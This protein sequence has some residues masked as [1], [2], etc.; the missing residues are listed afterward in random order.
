MLIIIII[1]KNIRE[2]LGPI[3]TTFLSR[4]S[5]AGPSPKK[6]TISLVVLNY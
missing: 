1:K 2:G 6:A 5:E 4:S 3:T